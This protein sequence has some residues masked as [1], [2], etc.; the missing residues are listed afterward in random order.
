MPGI[1]FS[2]SISFEFVRLF[3]N[4]DTVN[5]GADSKRFCVNGSAGS[6]WKWKLELN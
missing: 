2:M 4:A 5:G 3:A 1:I 6:D